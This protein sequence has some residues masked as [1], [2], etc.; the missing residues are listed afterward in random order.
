MR[1]FFSSTCAHAQYKGNC[2]RSFLL[3]KVL[4]VRV[5]LFAY[6]IIY[7]MIIQSCCCTV[8]TYRRET[9]R[10]SVVDESTTTHSLFCNHERSVLTRLDSGKFT[11]TRSALCVFS[12][13]H[14]RYLQVFNH[15]ENSSCCAVPLG[16]RDP[17]SSLQ[18]SK[19]TKIV[20]ALTLGVIV[21]YPCATSNITPTED[22]VEKQRWSDHHIALIIVCWH[23]FALCLLLI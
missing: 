3:R 19:L 12:P 4:G 16:P 11:Y 21:M 5:K 13:T 18:M 8:I 2:I 23:T 17:D 20:F 14:L 1:L 7:N 22:P 15:S 9:V 10:F 6:K